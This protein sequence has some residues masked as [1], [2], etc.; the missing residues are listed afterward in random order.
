MTPKRCIRHECLVPF[1][2]VLGRFKIVQVRASPCARGEPLVCCF[3]VLCVFDHLLY[4]SQFGVNEGEHAISDRDLFLSWYPASRLKSL[5][6]GLHA[7]ELFGSPSSV[8]AAVEVLSR[9]PCR[10]SCWTG[11]QGTPYWTVTRTNGDR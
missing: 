1:S 5:V 6:L 8:S 7:M 2:P 9:R 4:P 10:D 3:S 11:D